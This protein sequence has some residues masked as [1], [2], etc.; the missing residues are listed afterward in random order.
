[1]KRFGLLG[2][3]LLAASAVCADVGDL[4]PIDCGPEHALLQQYLYVLPQQ[5][6][7]PAADS[8]T[9]SPRAVVA[10]LSGGSQHAGATTIKVAIDSTEP[11]AKVPNVLRLDFTGKGKFSSSPDGAEVR[12]LESKNGTYVNKQSIT[13]HSLKTGDLIR[14]R[15]PQLPFRA[16][17]SAPAEI[18]PSPVPRPPRNELRRTPTV[19]PSLRSWLRRA[20]GWRSWRRT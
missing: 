3:V 7:K 18:T 4:T 16:G 9:V 2:V 1:M 15:L 20:M 6:A 13:T 17:M 11:N 10:T 5:F 8:G 19:R 14:K 12:D